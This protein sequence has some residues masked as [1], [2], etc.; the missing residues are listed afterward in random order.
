[1]K[2]AG[3]YDVFKQMMRLKNEQLHCQALEA[4]MQRKTD[5]SI[6]N[7]VLEYPDD[8]IEEAIR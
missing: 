8:D 3:D 6:S 4:I 2:S 1:M 7:S 5:P